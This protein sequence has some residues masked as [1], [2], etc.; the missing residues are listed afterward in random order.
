MKKKIIISVCIT[1]LIIIIISGIFYINYEYK[2]S[3]D[4]KL[5]Q[6]K[7]SDT[8]IKII[9]R[10]NIEK[11]VLKNEYSKTLEIA[12]IKNEFDYN[13]L[14][15]YF[16]MDYINKDDYIEKLNILSK[17]GYDLSEIK[18]ILKNIN[19]SDLD[20][21]TNNEYISNLKDYLKYKYFKIS[22]LNRY[23]DYRNNNN[24]DIQ[25]VILNVNMNLDKEPYEYYNTITD[26]ENILIL[27]NKYNKLP[28]NYEPN[29]LN[30]INSNNSIRE[31]Y[32]KKEACDAFELM[33]ND[34]KTLGLNII[35]ISS[36]RTK[37]YQKNLY[38]DYV[39]RNGVTKA[40]TYS[41]R[42][43]FSEHETGLALDVM[44]SNKNYTKFAYTNEYE[45]V[46]ENAYNYGFIIRYPENKEDITKYIYE[47]WH[48][49]YV[50][51]DVAKYIYDN[52]L[53]LE[54]YLALGN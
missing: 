8:A 23:I 42:P 36:Y 49:R 33:C 25:N 41:A 27:V 12:L 48:L 53:T 24:L 1:L 6:L 20:Y 11:K 44:G 13:N 40:D 18:F 51:K 22:N 5:K 52:N 45:W 46:K 29:D 16:N 28:D 34:A 32:L 43:R 7:Y 21:I 3:N 54:E 50:G 2:N 4:Y 39:N 47:S 37:E 17:L 15:L 19:Y 10:E 26:T 9:E 35:A 31:L 14:D 38:N 30:K